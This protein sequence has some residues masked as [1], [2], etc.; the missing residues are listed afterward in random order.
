MNDIF[1]EHVLNKLE[2]NKIVQ[3]TIKLLEKYDNNILNI[4]KN[5]TEEENNTT[6]NDTKKQN[7]ENILN[8]Q[9]IE[10]PKLLTH[11]DFIDIIKEL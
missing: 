6:T 4:F 3:D 5:S 9:D 2:N 1:L 11:N 10:I 8:N 7:Y